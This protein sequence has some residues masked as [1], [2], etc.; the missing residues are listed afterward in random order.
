MSRSV[1]YKVCADERIGVPGGFLRPGLPGFMCLLGILAWPVKCSYDPVLYEAPLMTRTCCVLI[2]L[3]SALLCGCILAYILPPLDVEPGSCSKRSSS[4]S[5]SHLWKASSCTA[6][7][8]SSSPSL[9]EP[10]SSTKSSLLP[11]HARPTYLGDIDLVRC[12][13]N[14]FHVGQREFVVASIE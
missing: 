13:P 12:W 4:S 10:R 9:P 2:D 8:S 11:L 7:R 1:T 6:V 5:F 14:S 3:M